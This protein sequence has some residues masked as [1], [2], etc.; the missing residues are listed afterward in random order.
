VALGQAGSAIGVE[1]LSPDLVATDQAEDAMPTRSRT[2][3]P[4]FTTTLALAV[5]QLEREMIE[6]ALHSHAGNISETAKALG[7]TRRGLYL[8][9][10]RLGFESV[11]RVDTK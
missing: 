8:K 2:R 6:T 4:G 5:D 10:R 7:L 3:K 9:L 1:H 11:S